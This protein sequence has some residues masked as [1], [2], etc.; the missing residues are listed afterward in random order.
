EVTLDQLVGLGLALGDLE[1]LRELALLLSLRRLGR[2]VT[3]LTALAP[4]QQHLPDNAEEETQADDEPDRDPARRA[5]VGAP[6]VR[7]QLDVADVLVA[8][9]VQ[10]PVQ[11]A[12]GCGGVRTSPG[13]RDRREHP[14]HL[15]DIGCADRLLARQALPRGVAGAGDLLR[16]LVEALRGQLRLDCL[17]LGPARD[18]PLEMNLH[19]KEPV[20]QSLA[21]EQLHRRPVVARSLE[22]RDAEDRPAD[23]NDRNEQEQ[24]QL[25]MRRHRTTC[26]D[27]IEGSSDP[28]PGEAPRPAVP[29]PVTTTARRR[30]HDD[31]E[32]VAKVEDAGRVADPGPRLINREL[33]WLTSGE[34]VL[35]LAADTSVP[36]LERVKF[37]G[38]VS[39]MLDEF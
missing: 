38:I 2:R 3:T 4:H 33:S 15:T 7:D 28:R 21:A 29:H 36:L 11:T 9:L 39:M 13:A 5:Q 32:M 6:L 22:L 37:C 26:I 8:E 27:P 30:L 24:P 34:R 35:D 23:R 18:I 10:K 19:V 25:G 16:G 12:L 20:E 14:A 1:D 17:E 31:A